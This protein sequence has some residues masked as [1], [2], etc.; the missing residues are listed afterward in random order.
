MIK[1][2]KPGTPV[3][4]SESGKPVMALFDLLGRRWS[5]GIIWNLS[6]SPMNFRQLQEKCESISPTILNTR[7]KE[8]RMA[9][10]IENSDDGYALTELGE[11]L[12]Q[13]L[14]PFKNYAI[15]WGNL[16]KEK[17]ERS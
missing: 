6:Q 16:L 15:K 12:F 4:G 13:L 10:L 8:F 11:E 5:M 2:P 14:H 1:I 3:R 17:E 7:I 9:L